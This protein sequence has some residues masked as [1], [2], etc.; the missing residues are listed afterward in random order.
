M[1]GPLKP[2]WARGFSPR[3]QSPFHWE[4]QQVMCPLRVPNLNRR[5]VQFDPDQPGS[6]EGSDAS[7]QG[8]QWLEADP[9]FLMCHV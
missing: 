3:V 7:R 2:G 4:S 6:R 9:S 8:A 1:Q 5:V